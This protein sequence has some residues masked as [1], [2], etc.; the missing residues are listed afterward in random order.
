LSCVELAV[1]PVK[2][3]D[4]LRATFADAG[5]D[6][7]LHV[8]DVD[9]DEEIALG[10]DTVVVSASVFKVAVALEFFRQAAAGRLESTERVRLTAAER[11]LG[12]T[13]LSVFAD[14]AEVSLRDLAAS[15]LVVSDNAATDVL[16]HRVGL[17]R[18]NAL[19]RSLG[20]AQTLITSDLRSMMDGIAQ[21]AGLAD[22]AAL[23][24]L[25]PGDLDEEG[26][27]RLLE[28]L[29]SC[30]A[31]RSERG[32]RTTPREMTTLL[33]AIWRDEAALPQ[34]CAE[35]RRLMGLQLTRHRIAAGFPR[36]VQVSA[37]TGS[38]VGS[39]RNEIG[40]VEYPDDRRY[41]VA[42]FTRAHALYE[43]ENEINAAIAAVAR[44]A[45]ETLRA[46]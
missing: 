24:N 2:V 7:F 15:M 44:A 32:I 37:K 36:E 45:V 40:V 41:A 3:E 16:I 9:G 13:G 10:A 38:L 6:G 17:E 42:V 34:C 18:I 27:A 30:E 31:L 46:R 25:R 5:C 26:L 1:S 22:W 43:R 21:D 39:V 20:L 4:Q 29:R 35:V 14:D 11:T 12:P 23:S 28:K 33:R 19:T 8:V